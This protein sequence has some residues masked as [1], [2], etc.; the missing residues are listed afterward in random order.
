MNDLSSLGALGLALPSP[1]YL[2]GSILFGILGYVV[3]RRGR[4]TS[5]PTLTWTG[6]ALMLYPYVVSQTWLLWL[7][8]AAMCGWAY[9][10]WE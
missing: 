9:T 1:A 6:V 2:A 10:R 7:L 5:T 4:K 8:G 3:F